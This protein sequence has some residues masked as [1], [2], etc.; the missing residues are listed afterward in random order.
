MVDRPVELPK[1][2]PQP[3]G[4]PVL[5]LE[6]VAVEPAPGIEALNDLQLTVHAGEI[7]GIAG[8]SG[9]GQRSL[10]A[11]VAGT[12]A[13][14]RGR[15]QLGGAAWPA[16]GPKAL[17]AAGVG[18]IPEDRQRQGVVGDM[19]LWENLALEGYDAPACRRFGLLNLAAFR[20]KAKALAERFDI[21]GGGIERPTRLLSGGN[22]QK[23]ILA[24]VLERSPRL[25][26]ASQP[27][28]G[29]DIGAVAA[30]HRHLLDARARGAGILLITED[31]DE[32]LQLSDRVRVLYRGRLGPS[33]PR[34]AIDLAR[35]GLEMAGQQA[36]AAADAA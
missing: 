8:V 32:L 4:D 30:V 9:N 11:L 34:A 29:L 10:A 12:L 26:L 2:Q 17:V 5:E 23:L 22:M 18:R 20:Q 3:A 25:I 1:A 31:L 7:L 35:L 14:S 24:R 13:A 21:R 16:G 6:A 28:R 36:T 27:T 33:R 19:T 15:L